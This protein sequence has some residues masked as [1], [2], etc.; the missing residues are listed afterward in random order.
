MKYEEWQ[1]R[2]E[3]FVA[4][5]AYTIDQF[6]SLLPYFKEAQQSGHISFRVRVEHVVGVVRRNTERMYFN[7]LMTLKKLNIKK[8]SDK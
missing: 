6:N 1:K 8:L 4:M 2:A 3:C 7:S 5:T